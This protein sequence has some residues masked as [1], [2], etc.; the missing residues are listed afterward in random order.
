MLLVIVINI[1]MMSRKN[2]W[3]ISVINHYLVVSFMC[4]FF[5]K[6]SNNSILIYRYLILSRSI[7]LTFIKIGKS[8]NYQK[9]NGEICYQSKLHTKTVK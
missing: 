1:N 5:N 8:S 3:A 6:L 2:Q 7:I 4:Y 9:K